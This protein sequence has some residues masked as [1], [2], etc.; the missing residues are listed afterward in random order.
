[1]CLTI[2]KES[3]EETKELKTNK[4]PIIAYKILQPNMMSQF[5]KFQWKLG[6]NISNRESSLLTEQEIK[7]MHVNK[8]FHFFTDKP[9]VCHQLCLY[10]S[11]YPCSNL[12]L[13]P[14]PYQC[15]ADNLVN[16][17]FKVQIQPKDIIAIGTW[18]NINSLAATK[19]TIIE[20]IK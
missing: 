4:K 7:E 8:G 18:N 17:V 6:E 12:Y 19:C 14:R 5:K 16:K 3:I 11:P 1:M 2:T 20:E 13:Y 10:P 15:S 9:E